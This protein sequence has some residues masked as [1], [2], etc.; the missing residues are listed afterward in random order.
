MSILEK[1]SICSTLKENLQKGLV[2][3]CS[4]V[5]QVYYLLFN[6]VSVT[7]K[8][9]ILSLSQHKKTKKKK[10]HNT[11]QRKPVHCLSVTLCSILDDMDGEGK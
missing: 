10:I 7:K 2:H 9:T 1:K 11:L 6:Y 5:V 4:T 8:G 3:Q